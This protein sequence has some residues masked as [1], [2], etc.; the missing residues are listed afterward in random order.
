MVKNGQR[1]F[2]TSFDHFLTSKMVK[3]LDAFWRVT[4]FHAFR[5]ILIFKNSQNWSNSQNETVEMV[6]RRR[7]CFKMVNVKTSKM[8]KK[9]SKVVYEPRKMVKKRQK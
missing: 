6:K 1:Q 4:Y 9:A 5:P 2:L 8:V 3:T 7:K